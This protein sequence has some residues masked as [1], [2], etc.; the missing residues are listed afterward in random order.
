MIFAFLIWL[1]KKSG[2]VGTIGVGSFVI[3]VD[4]LALLDLPSIPGIPKFPA[5]TEIIYSLF[6]IF[7]LSQRNI[8]EKFLA[9]S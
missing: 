2:W 3:V 6:G 7:Y 4:S 5:V 8:R 1:G 9:K